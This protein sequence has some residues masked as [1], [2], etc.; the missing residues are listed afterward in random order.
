MNFQ[1]ARAQY[2]QTA[3]ATAPVVEDPHEIVHFTLRELG[4]SLRVL[5]IATQD[6]NPPP[7]E[8]L[9][10][11]FTAIY[12][13]QSSLDFDRGGE[14]ADNL[15]AVYEFCR[16]QV[17]LAFARTPGARLAEAAD[18]IAAITGAWADMPA[19]RGVGA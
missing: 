13:L 7:A 4:R 8:H 11:A 5:A 17:A 6:G 19:R 1:L 2:R 18:H 14:I 16:Q 9:N 3:G 10:R 15:F 12:I